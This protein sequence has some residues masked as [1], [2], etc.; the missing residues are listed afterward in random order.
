MDNTIISIYASRDYVK[1][2]ER[3]KLIKSIIENDNE[4]RMV[5]C[6]EFFNNMYIAISVS[7]HHLVWNYE[8][9][10]SGDNV[11]YSINIMTRYH[12]D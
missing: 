1:K 10:F 5:D 12:R 8:F 4:E 6:Y 9:D 11:E 3:K 2:S 7:K